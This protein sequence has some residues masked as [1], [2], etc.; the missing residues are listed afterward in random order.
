MLNYIHVF[1]FIFCALYILDHYPEIKEKF[2]NS[3]EIF[4]INPM[5]AEVVQSVGFS[6]LRRYPPV[7]VVLK[8][9]SPKTYKFR[10]FNQVLWH[11][12]YYKSNVL[13]C[14]TCFTSN[15]YEAYKIAKEFKKRGSKVVM[16][17]PHVTYLPHEALAF[18]DS[19]V[20]GQAEGVWREVIRDYE[21]GTLKPQY[22]GPATEADYAQVHE[23]LL[24]SPPSI[25]KEFL[26]TSRGCKFRCHFCT[27][28]ALSGGTGA[29]SVYQRYC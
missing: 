7:F 21:N 14:I 4:L 24:N 18:C 17:G 11:E 25:V 27:I 5:G 9:L 16:G 10:E 19:V 22:R 15:C 29:S 20:I 28:P 6:G 26:E 12:R 8:A 13:V 2:S 3:K 1:E 23:E